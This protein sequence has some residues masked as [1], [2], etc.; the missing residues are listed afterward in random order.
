MITFDDIKPG[1]IIRLVEG[2]TELPLSGCRRIP[3]GDFRVIK[4]RPSY[5]GKCG[6][7]EWDTVV[8]TVK[9]SKTGKQIGK[10]VY[11]YYA[12]FY[13]KRGTLVQ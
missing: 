12:I 5:A 4:I 2:D 7:T 13:M 8:E 6:K 3:K 10:W 11:T 1:V 9:V